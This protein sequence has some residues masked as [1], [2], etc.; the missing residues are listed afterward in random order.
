[1]TKWL[2]ALLA[3]SAFALLAGCGGD[4]D[5]DTTPTTT[6]AAAVETIDV[7]ETEYALDPA[8]P[9][10]ER[11]GEVVFN[12]S[13]D[14]DVVHALEV[15]GPGGEQE[16]EEIDPGQSATLRVDFDRA[17]SYEWYCPIGNHREL[18]MEGEITVG[19]RGGGT[20]TGTRTGTTETE[21]TT[22]GTTE[23]ETNE[24]ETG[25]TETDDSGGSNS[26]PG[27]GEEETGGSRY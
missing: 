24:T 23:T 18:G 13:N 17:G 1:M 9:T 4:D 16:T 2:A 11:A 26:G 5:D 8:N 25:E 14:G 19:G 10:I 20:T 12:V 7:S 3:A 22:T 21:T 6:P 27:S 15:E